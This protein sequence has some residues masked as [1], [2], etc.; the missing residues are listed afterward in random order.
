MYERIERGEENEKGKRREKE[1]K[2]GSEPKRK[3][4]RKKKRG[5][6]RIDPEES[7]ER[8]NKEGRKEIY[9]KKDGERGGEGGGGMDISFPPP[10]RELEAATAIPHRLGSWQSC[11]IFTV[12]AF[13]LYIYTRSC[14]HCGHQHF[15]IPVWLENHP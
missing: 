6:N 13:S 10:Y 11:K 9:K 5:E 7:E 8:W 2:E 12:V 4:L 1:E 14:Q 15:V 3:V